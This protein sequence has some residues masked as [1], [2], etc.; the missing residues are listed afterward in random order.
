MHQDLQRHV[1]A[2]DGIGGENADD[3]RDDHAECPAHGFEQDD[4]QCRA[5]DNVDIRRVSLAHNLFDKV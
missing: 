5:E 1:G 4:D 3:D 2:E